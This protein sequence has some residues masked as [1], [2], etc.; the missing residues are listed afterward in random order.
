MTKF[1]SHNTS[2]NPKHPLRGDDAFLVMDYSSY[3][4]PVSAA[5]HPSPQIKQQKAVFEISSEI[6]SE[7]FASGAKNTP[8]DGIVQLII[9]IDGVNALSTQ[10]IRSGWKTWIHV[11]SSFGIKCDNNPHAI[12]IHVEQWVS[13]VLEQG[14]RWQPILDETQTL[15]FDKPSTKKLDEKKKGV[16]QKI[17]DKIML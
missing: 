8:Y 15:R 14:G 6:R 4:E 9:D 11:V 17:K 7:V 13:E 16:M 12:H 2:V 5:L 10:E 3:V 1:S